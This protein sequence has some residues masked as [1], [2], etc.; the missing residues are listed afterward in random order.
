MKKLKAEM[1]AAE[2]ADM[3]KLSVTAVLPREFENAYRMG[4]LAGK[5]STLTDVINNYSTL[6]KHDTTTG[7][8]GKPSAGGQERVE[9]E[10]P[11]GDVR[12]VHGEREDKAGD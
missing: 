7:S 3:K 6:F 2:E 8:E 9:A 1:S 12:S 11:E 4:F 10:G 5:V